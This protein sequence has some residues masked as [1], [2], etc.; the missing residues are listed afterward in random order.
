[1][2]TMLLIQAIEAD[3]AL[4]GRLVGVPSGMSVPMLWKLRYDILSKSSDQSVL[5]YALDELFT[6]ES[7]GILLPA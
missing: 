1:R 7:M 6:G 4:G 2:L 5:L 3:K